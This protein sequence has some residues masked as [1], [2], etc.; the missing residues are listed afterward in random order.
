MAAG[1]IYDHLGG[2]FHRYSVDGR[3]L[4]PHFEKMLYDNAQ[5]VRIYLDAWRLTK[6]DRFRE[7]VEDT[8]EYIRRELTHPDGAFFA[9]QDA[10]SEGHEG[11]YFVWEPKRLP[12]CWEPT[13]LRS[14]VDSMG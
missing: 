14:F 9:A 1:G 5:L 2:G 4:V 11:S 3:W 6:E 12:R 8:L 7:V 13:W 10:D